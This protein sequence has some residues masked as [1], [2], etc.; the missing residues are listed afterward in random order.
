MEMP[1]SYRTYTQIPKKEVVRLVKA[2]YM[3]NVR[4]IMH[5]QR[6]KNNR[7]NGMCRLCTYVCIPPKISI[8]KGVL[9]RKEYANDRYVISTRNNKADGIKDFGQEDIM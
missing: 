9:E 4:Y 6:N 3:R 1:I 8:S 7:R 5:I 2:Q